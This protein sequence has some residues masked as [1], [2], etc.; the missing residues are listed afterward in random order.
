MRM[1]YLHFFLSWGGR[2]ELKDYLRKGVSYPRKRE[3]KSREQTEERIE[4]LTRKRTQRKTKISTDSGPTHV[5]WEKGRNG[6]NLRAFK[7]RKTGRWR[8]DRLNLGKGA[9][10]KGEG[11]KK[12]RGKTGDFSHRWVP[13]EQQGKGNFWGG[14]PRGE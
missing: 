2:E 3:M 6:G 11:A 1:E 8:R 4:V 13:N 12:K 7:I 5:G 10:E 14:V 9:G